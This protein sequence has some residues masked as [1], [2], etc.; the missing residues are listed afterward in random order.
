MTMMFEVEDLAVASPATVSRCGMVYM[1]PE[2]LT[3]QPLIKSWLESL[4]EKI[5]EK[6]SIVKRLGT[7][8]ENIM[9][10]GCYYMRKNCIEPVLT[11]NN[12]LCQSSF[13]ILDSYFMKYVDTEIKQIEKEEIDDLESMINELV[14]YSLIWSIGATTNN[15]G[16]KRMDAFLRNKFN[17]I[18]IDFPKEQTIY[19][20]CFN[21]KDKE[22]VQWLDIIPG[23][24]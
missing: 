4:P 18:K 9:D 3:L 12:N 8:Y 19:D 15:D 23:Y 7:I 13:R 5:R 6:E 22:W 21:V 14:A 24:N 17:E 16:R 10:D 20:W 1:E 2:S 11:V